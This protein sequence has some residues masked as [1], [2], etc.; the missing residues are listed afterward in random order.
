MERNITLYNPYD[1]NIITG[2]LAIQPSVN[3]DFNPVLIKQSEID[4]DFCQHSFQTSDLTIDYIFFQEH[5]YSLN[6]N[7]K[8][9]VSF[10]DNV[11]VIYNKEFDIR[12]WGKTK[13]E[14]I[15]AFHFNFHSLYTNFVLE[16]DA[17]LSKKAKILKARLV[18]KVVL[19]L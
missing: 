4:I 3:P 13:N 15:E 10:E 14:A 17:N 18:E 2:P 6:E 8:C 9:E 1:Q 11:L 7:L 16:K 5:F 19:A 12:A